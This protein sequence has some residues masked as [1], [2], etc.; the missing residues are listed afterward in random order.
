MKATYSGF[1][2]KKSSNYIDLPPVGAYIGEIQAAREAEQNGRPVIELFME[3]TEGEYK[4]RFTDVYNDQKERFGQDKAKY[5]GIFKLIPPMD[6]DEDWRYRAFEGNIWCVEE[7]NPGFKFRKP[8]GTWDEQGLAGKTIGLNLRNRIYNYTASD[9]TVK[10]G[11]VIEI[12]RFET[13]QNVHNGKVKAAKD[14]DTRKVKE[15]EST[16]V[17][18][19]FTAVNT[20]LPPWG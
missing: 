14:R 1:E 8:D 9:E 16:S 12:A 13:V 18:N 6:G 15:E 11:K 10:E 4:G 17:P 19:G 3:I 20:E 7:S 2:A 5:K